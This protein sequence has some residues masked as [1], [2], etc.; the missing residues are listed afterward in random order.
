M[1]GKRLLA[2]FFGLHPSLVSE[3]HSVMKAQIPGAK[4]GVLAAYGEVLTHHYNSI[5]VATV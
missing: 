3:I 2:Y 1:D 4:K 5:V